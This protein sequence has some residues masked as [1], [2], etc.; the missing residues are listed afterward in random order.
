MS[1]APFSFI[2]CAL[3]SLV[4]DIRVL[5][6]RNE[7]KAVLPFTELSLFLK[8]CRNAYIYN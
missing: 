3:V 7:F 2:R 4:E 8:A 1:E 5:V 6:H